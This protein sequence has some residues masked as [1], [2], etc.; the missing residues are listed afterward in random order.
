MVVSFQVWVSSARRFLC[1]YRQ[2]AVEARDKNLGAW[3]A[4]ERR[5]FAAMI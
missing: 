4:H 3:I 2:V 1:E 5:G